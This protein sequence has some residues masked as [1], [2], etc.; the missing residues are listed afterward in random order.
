MRLRKLQN[1]E[2]GSSYPFPTSRKR[3]SLPSVDRSTTRKPS[4]HCAMSTRSP[5]LSTSPG[6]PHVGSLRQ[7]EVRWEY[8]GREHM[9]PTQKT[10]GQECPP[11]TSPNVSQ[12]GRVATKSSSSRRRR[13]VKIRKL[14]CGPSSAVLL[15]VLAPGF[16]FLVRERHTIPPTRCAAQLV[17][18]LPPSQQRR[19]ATC[20]CRCTWRNS[21]R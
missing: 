21:C 13:Q 2:M 16:R 6:I 17:S 12:R 1:C 11:H 15:A 4:R 18:L 3:K 8:K 5:T 19:A 9:V 14:S 10:R 7:R 20:N